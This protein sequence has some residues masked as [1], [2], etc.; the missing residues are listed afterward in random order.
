V[1]TNWNGASTGGGD[2]QL[3]FGADA[4]GLTAGQLN[5]IRFIDPAGFPPGAHFAGILATGEVVPVARPG[6]A[7]ARVGRN[8]VLSWEGNLLLERQGR[9]S[10]VAHAA[11][12]GRRM[13]ALAQL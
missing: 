8:L 2:D 10:P 12:L 7:H 11:L 9:L 13:N 6:L 5:Q 1:V 3:K 4:S